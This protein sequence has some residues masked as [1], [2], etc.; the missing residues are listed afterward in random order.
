MKGFPRAAALLPI[1]RQ[2]R[3]GA[4]GV[5][6]LRNS[7]NL[8]YRAACGPGDR[9]LLRLTPERHR[10]AAQIAGELAFQLYLYDNGAPVVTPLRAGDR[11]ILPV[12]MGGR[13]YCAAAFSWADGRNWDER[14]DHEPEIFFRIGKALGHIHRL[15]KAYVPA[16]TEKRRLWSESQHLLRAPALLQAYNPALC[17]I[18]RECM[19]EIKSLPADGADFGL[20][21]GDYLLSN[22]MITKDNRV[23]VF[24]FDECEYAWY[25]MDLAICMH[26]YLI[27][28]APALLPAQADAAEAML[29]VLLRGYTSET[30]VSREMLLRLQ[31][32][33]RVRDFIYLSSILEKNEKLTG[34]NKAFAETCT[35]RLLNHRPFLEF[36]MERARELLESS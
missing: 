30:P 3:P 20:T 4:S 23:T 13:S 6:F 7:H 1:S 17:G 24:D 32:L 25:A 12:T 27:G 33:F 26:C 36:S 9:F 5:A 18:F 35:D 2:F 29:Y 31:S 28:P 16:G 19:A 34:W 14:C 11:Y 22:Y 10:D 15:S 8:I 21:H